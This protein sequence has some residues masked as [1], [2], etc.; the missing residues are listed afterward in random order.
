[1]ERI[2]LYYPTIEF[3][4]ENWLRQALLYSDKVSSILPYNVESRIPKSLLPLLEKGEYKPIYTDELM[5][6]YGHD[7]W[8]FAKK[9]LNEIDN[10]PNIYSASSKC[11]H[12]D[13]VDTLYYNKI[14][15]GL[16]HEL[17]KRKLITAREPGKIHLPENI[18]LYY[19][20]ILAKFIAS[21]VEEDIMIPSTDYKRFSQMSFENG[22]KSDNAMNLIFQ[23]CLPVP[24]NSVE[25]SKIIDFKNNHLQ[26]LK[27]FRMFYTKIQNSLKDCRDKQDLK[28]QLVALKETI[29]IELAELEKLYTKNKFKIIYS[30][31]D[32]LFGIENPKLFNS[33]LGAG[34]ISTVI[35]PMI[36]LGFGAVIV[37][38]KIIDNFVSKPN[39][40]SEFN[41]LF[42]ARREG[43]IK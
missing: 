18:A 31:L 17:E 24:D 37:T 40:T 15:S 20:S 10:N 2:L 38:G 8:P 34:V 23:N 12:R 22:I 13:I 5:Y 43:I 16:L 19:M 14:S 42:E 27:R 11:A 26:D 25:I 39:Q 6:K 29:D 30:S 7:Y 36:G 33:L 28:E 9:F 41:Y 1:M 35:N 3:P 4:K 21:V 32:S